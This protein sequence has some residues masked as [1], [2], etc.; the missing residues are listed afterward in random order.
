[1]AIEAVT[2]LLGNIRQQCFT[3]KKIKKTFPLNTSIAFNKR[4]S[5]LRL[6]IKRMQSERSTC[7]LLVTA[8]STIVHVHVHVHVYLEC[9]C[10]YMSDKA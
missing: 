8:L 2:F 6:G 7:I 10:F 4:I 3:L 1:M 5:Q 9:A